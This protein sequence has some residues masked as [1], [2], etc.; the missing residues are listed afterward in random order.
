MLNEFETLVEK[1]P[2]M[3]SFLL[4]YFQANNIFLDQ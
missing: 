3:F 4:L 1:S 2:D